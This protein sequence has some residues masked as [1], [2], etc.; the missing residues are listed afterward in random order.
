M[1]AFVNGYIRSYGRGSGEC[2]GT[3]TCGPNPVILHLM[4]MLELLVCPLTRAPLRRDES[5]NFLVTDAGIKYPIQDGI[6]VLLS[7]AAI[8]PANTA[9]PLKP[10]PPT[11]PLHD[12]TT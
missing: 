9:E 12:A 4:D 7:S 6:P 2:D 11:Q 5:G 10:A 1:L 8:L 3:S